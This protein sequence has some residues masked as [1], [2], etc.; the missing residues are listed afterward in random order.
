MSEKG[1][2]GPRWKEKESDRVSNSPATRPAHASISDLF[3]NNRPINAPSSLPLSPTSPLLTR[4]HS[5]VHGICPSTRAHRSTQRLGPPLPPTRCWS[6]PLSADDHVHFRLFVSAETFFCL[7]SS[8]S[9]PSQSANTQ[10]SDTRYHRH[11]YPRRLTSF[12]S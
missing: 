2:K 1:K 9:T 7:P 8:P 10:R 6:I 5:P 11:L 12:R 3:N 4:L